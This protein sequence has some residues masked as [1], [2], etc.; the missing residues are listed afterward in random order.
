[1]R[2]PSFCFLTG[3]LAPAFALA[4]VAPASGQQ[5]EIPALPVPPA[6]AARDPDAICAAALGGAYDEVWMLCRNPTGAEAQAMARRAAPRRHYRAI[7][8]ARYGGERMADL[9]I[10]AAR[11]HSARLSDSQ[12]DRRINECVARAPGRR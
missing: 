11:E 2:A 7:L 10:E 3:L 1:M 8:I 12:Y 5:T 6:S 4:A 9:A